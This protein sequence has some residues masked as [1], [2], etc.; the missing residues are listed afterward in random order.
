MITQLNP[1]TALIIIDLQ[2]GILE[3]AEQAHN[4]QGFQP[5]QQAISCISEV[6]QN[7]QQL[8]SAFR[9]HNL[10]IV[11]V[12]VNSYGAKWTLTRKDQAN[13]ATEA[14]PEKF[15]T[16]VDDFERL[17]EDLRITKSSWSA[18]FDT[19]LDEQLKAKGITQIVFAGVA[20]SIG[21]EGSA[22]DASRLAYQISFAADAMS[23]F[24]EAAHQHSVQRMFP[25]LGEVG[26]T[27]DICQQLNHTQ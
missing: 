16:L 4:H 11:W 15:Y 18:F 2:Y 22:R 8:V 27:S 14:P 26:M 13:A 19:D 3:L 9:Q 23:D 1:K 21:V 17:P 5:Q 7:T 10:P 12:N 20:T 6:L 24:T 25:R